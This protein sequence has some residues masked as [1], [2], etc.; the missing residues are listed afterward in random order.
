V[1][2]V[3]EIIKVDVVAVVETAVA[4]GSYSTFKFRILKRIDSPICLLA[5]L[6][7][8]SLYITVLFG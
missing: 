8:S 5:A 2:K 3:A 6:Q 4:A 1:V 7:R